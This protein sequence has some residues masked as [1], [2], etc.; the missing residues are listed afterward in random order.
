M[1][2]NDFRVYASPFDLVHLYRL[3][4]QP[5]RVWVSDD[6]KCSIFDFSFS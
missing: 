1:Q 5:E 6:R 3:E 4:P 2:R